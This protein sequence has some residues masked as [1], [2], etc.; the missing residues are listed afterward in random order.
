M[1]CLSSEQLAMLTLGNPQKDG[2]EESEATRDHLRRCPRCALALA[3]LQEDL[4][5]VAAAHDWFDQ[6]H[7]TARDRLLAA[8]PGVEV[9]RGA[10][11]RKSPLA[12]MKE[13]LEMRRTWIGGLA[14][15]VVLGLFL[16]WHVTG[17]PSALAQTAR[18]L[19]EVESYRC[20][21]SGMEPGAD[22]E[23]DRKEV[24]L[25]TWAAPGLYRTETRESGKLIN[26]SVLIRG[27]PGLEV[28]H[29][30]E[31]F[32]RLEPVY[33]ADSPLELLHE[34]TRFA[35]KADRELPVRKLAGKAAR[36]FEITFDKID[37]DRDVGTLRV[38]T[39]PETKLP[40]RVELEEPDVCKMIFDEFAWNVPTAKL[41]D[42]RP[43]AKYQDETPVPMSSEEETTHIVKA[44]KVY[45]RYCGKYPPAKIVY[46]D[47]TSRRLFKAAGL[48]DPHKVAPREE[49]LTE[50]Y[51]ECSPVRYGFA[52]IN[53]IQQHNPDAVY[54]GKTVG[55]DNKGKVL[56][57]WK[58]ADGD[59]QVLFGDLRAETVKPEK[60]ADLEKR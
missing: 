6:G 54:H 8:L 57:R 18:A 52:V 30:Y 44:L 2:P 14:A 17:S 19:R 26:V 53:S 20:R 40:L 25:L 34:L 41:F 32:K 48:S 51:A 43:P 60:L 36:G 13:V 37:P 3:R 35:G 33:Q 46:G 39:D 15:L 23:K 24:F 10:R 47:V 31:T 12:G 45:A 4:G 22:E 38:W 16:A 58:R 59:Y 56:F 5:R 49:Q 27:R 42:T 50:T 1:N 55:P 9:E 21:V 11:P 29:K 28:D 7:A